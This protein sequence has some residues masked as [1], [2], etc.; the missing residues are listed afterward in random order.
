MNYHHLLELSHIAD[1]EA[2]K[3]PNDTAAQY[4]AYALT[5][6]LISTIDSLDDT[7]YVAKG[8]YEL[9][10]EH[11]E[12]FWQSACQADPELRAVQETPQQD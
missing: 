8:M 5:L 10:H 4:K 2:R 12:E 11:L 9:C 7:D 1:Y 6:T 3:K